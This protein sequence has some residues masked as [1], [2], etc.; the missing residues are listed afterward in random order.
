MLRYSACGS[1]GS[2]RPKK[3]TAEDE[4]LRKRLKKNERIYDEGRGCSTNPRRLTKRPTGV[5]DVHSEGEGGELKR[6]MR[7]APYEVQ[8][9]NPAT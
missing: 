4:K 7:P 9:Y 8:C 3:G 5:L 1:V 2:N 6:R